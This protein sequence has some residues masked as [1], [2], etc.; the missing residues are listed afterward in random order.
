MYTYRLWGP[1]HDFT[2]EEVLSE[3]AYFRG[4]SYH[5]VHECGKVNAVQDCFQSNFTFYAR[6]VRSSCQ[7]TLDL[8]KWRD[9]PFD[10]C[11]YFQT[12]ETEL[13]ICYALNSKQIK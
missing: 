5:T 13:G 2:L 6:V 4:E 10:C 11:K 7:Q 9:K 1:D 8:C 12:M 3:I